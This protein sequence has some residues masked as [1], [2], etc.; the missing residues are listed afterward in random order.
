MTITHSLVIQNVSKP[1]KAHKPR[2]TLEQRIA[3]YVDKCPPAISGCGGHIQAYKV[4]CALTWGFGLDEEAAL[5]WMSVYN[6]KCDPPFSEAELRH[7]VRSALGGAH[8]QPR[9]YLLG[10]EEMSS[11]VDSLAE[12][13]LPIVERVE[14]TPPWPSI[15]LERIERIVSGGFGLYDLW[16]ASPIRFEHTCHES[17]SQEIIEI[18]FPGDPLLCCGQSWSRSD[19]RRR[20]VWGEELNQLALVVP[21]PMLED[22]GYTQ[23]GH[24]S[25]H[26]LEATA[27]RVYQVVE[28]DFAALDRKGNPTLWTGPIERWKASG[29]TIADAEAALHLHLSEHMPLACV[30]S[31][32]GKSLHG[33]Y[34]AFR[35]AGRRPASL[36]G[37]RRGARSRPCH[38]G[39]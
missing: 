5:Y 29:I 38:L 34:N 33:W 27:A 17:C 1:V 11:C 12:A 26:C 3:M 16:E 24:W 25:S 36:Y 22:G 31:S 13:D 37:T 23:E 28:F 9:G 20:L 30:T 8:N 4:A 39:P 21:N 10:S 15:D 18:L 19:T 32:G 2:P 35:P 6:Q 14:Q 7:K